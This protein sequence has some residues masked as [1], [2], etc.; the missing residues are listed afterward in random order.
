MIKP[1]LI[2]QLRPDQASDDEF[3]AFLKYGELDEQDV[4]RIRMEENGIPEINLDDYSAIIV[5]GGP[6][7]I[8][9][10]EEKKEEY[11]K[12]FEADMAPLLDEIIEK[13]FPYL[14]ACYGIGSIVNHMGGVVSKEKYTE[15]VGAV[16]VEFTEQGII[17]P[18]MNGLPKVFRAFAGHKE[19]CQTLPDNVVLLASTK[20]CPI[21]LVRVKNNIYATQFH[22]ELDVDGIIH[23]IN[24]Y[25]H[26]GYFPPEDADKL[27]AE[28]EKERGK[29]T[30]PQE[31]LK[32]FV[33]KYKTTI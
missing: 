32:R 15:H 12:R 1:F 5:G 6:S 25:K 29:I 33:E 18:L 8:S 2:L 10:D 19:A 31:I 16:D 11:Q 13:D 22:P 4:V 26:A 20:D 17:D 7:N 21:H 30:V 24:T 3:K 27:I 23:R 14:G 9:D 28:S